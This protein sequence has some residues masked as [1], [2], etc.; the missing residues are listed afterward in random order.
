MTNDRNILIL[1]NR[2]IGD[3]IISLSSLQYF[4]DL[5]PGSKL[6]F[7]V[8][9]WIVPLYKNSEINA[10]EI[11]PLKLN[12]IQGFVDLYELLLNKKRN[13]LS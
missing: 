13:L 9:D 4:K 10:D 3:S 12:S 11:V 7:G 8:P 2:A 5:N 6:Y 1:K